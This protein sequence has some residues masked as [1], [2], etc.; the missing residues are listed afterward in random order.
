MAVKTFHWSSP[1][2]SMTTFTFRPKTF[3][4][5]D[6]S[7]GISSAKASH[8]PMF[9]HLSADFNNVFLQAL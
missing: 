9:Y 1:I 2:M 8:Y 5:Q 7:T 4:F 3:S 6:A